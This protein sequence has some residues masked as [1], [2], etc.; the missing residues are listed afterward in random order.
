MLTYHFVLLSNPVIPVISSTDCTCDW[1]FPIRPACLWLQELLCT[2]RRHL[3]QPADSCPLI[4][5]LQRYYFFIL[6]QS[7]LPI[8]LVLAI[9][10]FS[11]HRMPRPSSLL[12]RLRYWHLLLP[13]LH[14]R[15]DGLRVRESQR[16]ELVVYD[17]K[18]VPVVSGINLHE[19]VI[20]A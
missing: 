2:G 1:A 11:P 6:P 17:V 16:L 7:L 12:L 8:F 19:Q 10:I 14:K 15:D 20:R 9:N 13:G 5:S 18:Q 3:R 4:F